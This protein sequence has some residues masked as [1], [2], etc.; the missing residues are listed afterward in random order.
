MF[1]ALAGI[2]AGMLVGSNLRKRFDHA[3]KV[4]RTAVYSS[5]SP[6]EKLIAKVYAAIRENGVS[7]GLTHEIIESIYNSDVVF[8]E[9]R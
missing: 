7:D 2:F 4:I 3:N 6:N 1:Y 8:Q 9:M 5:L